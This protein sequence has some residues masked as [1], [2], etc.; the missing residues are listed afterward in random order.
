MADLTIACQQL[1]LRNTP[2]GRRCAQS[3]FEHVRASSPLC[4]F[5]FPRAS[6]RR[7]VGG[8]GGLERVFSLC[9]AK[10]LGASLNIFFFLSPEILEM[11]RHFPRS[12]SAVP[13]GS[14]PWEGRVAISPSCQVRICHLTSRTLGAAQTSTKAP[15][16][17]FLFFAVKINHGAEI[18]PRIKWCNSLKCRLSR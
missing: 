8:L 18:V 13:R 3:T 5:P 12:L 1:F 4:L 9:S 16:F 15:D 6:L 10:R 11:R 14:L 2:S 17:F 7:G